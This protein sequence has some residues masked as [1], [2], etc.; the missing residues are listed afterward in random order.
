MFFSRPLY[1]TLEKLNVFL[2]LR[3]ED[4]FQLYPDLGN[5]LVAGYLFLSEHPVRR[6]R[7]LQ[8]SSGSASEILLGERA[9][10]NRGREWMNRG[11]YI[12]IV[13]S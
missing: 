5:L 4:V 9:W 1:G 13:L 8:G 3:T 7:R 10:S 11:C 12:H 2:A 6:S